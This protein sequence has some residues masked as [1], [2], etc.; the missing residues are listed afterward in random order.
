MTHPLDGVQAKLD[1]SLEHLDALVD[2]VGVFIKSEPYDTPIGY[3]G[4]GWDARYF[5]ILREPPLRLGIIAGDYAQNLRS[6]LD[7]L[8]YQLALLTTKSPQGTAFPICVDASSY[9]NSG[10]HGEPSLRDRCLAG[11]PDEHR[12]LIDEVQPYVGRS[13]AEAEVDELAYLSRFTNTDKHRVIHPAFGK[14]V[15]AD[16][17]A[18][19]GPADIEL[20]ITSPLP[21]LTEG[22]EIYRI[23][24]GRPTGTH[25]RVQVHLGFTIGFGTYGLSDGDFR[26][27]HAHVAQ[28]I[29]RFR[30]A[31]VEGTAGAIEPLP[32]GSI[33]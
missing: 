13:R 10:P 8:V 24:A 9:L 1:R 31:F 5:H 23:R 4:D 29:D 28:I 25:V 22:T 2:E 33:S 26:N 32:N 19:D 20:R 21:V 6:A 16:A 15:S 17:K 12:A 3:V 11:V 7:H 30:P 27:I 14:L 18:L